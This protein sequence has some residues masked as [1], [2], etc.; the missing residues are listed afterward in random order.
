MRVDDSSLPVT[1]C[2]ASH[3]NPAPAASGTFAYGL[4]F[5]ALVDPNS[6]SI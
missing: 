1:L 5:E 4:E 6:L 3:C 2:G